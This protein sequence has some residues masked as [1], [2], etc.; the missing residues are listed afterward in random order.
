M[1]LPVTDTSYATPVGSP[2]LCLS[3]TSILCQMAG[4]NTGWRCA[5]RVGRGDRDTSFGG[6]AEFCETMQLRPLKL[7]TK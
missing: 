2:G 3:T 1:V 5:R 4:F 7:V 6:C